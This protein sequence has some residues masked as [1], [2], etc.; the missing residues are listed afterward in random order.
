MRRIN[1]ISVGK[2]TKKERGKYEYKNKEK[3]VSAQEERDSK[4]GKE[5]REGP[6]NQ[7]GKDRIRPRQR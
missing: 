6:L 4:K 3:D 7:R 2:E 5:K 1:L